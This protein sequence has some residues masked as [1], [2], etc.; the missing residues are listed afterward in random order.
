MLK[1]IYLKFNHCLFFA[2]FTSYL[3]LSS[4]SLLGQKNIDTE[5]KW[6]GTWATAPQLVEPHNMPPEPGLTNNSLRQIVRVS[7]GGDTL[8]IKFSNEFST[9]PVTMKSVQI[10]V[11]TGENTINLST[12]KELTFGG[13][14]EITMD[15]GSAVTSDP[16]A[17]RLEPRMD[18][19]ITIYYGQTSETTTGHPGSRTT[20]YLL[21]GNSTA[22]TDFTGAVPTDHWYNINTIDVLASSQA[23]CVAILGNSITDGRGSITNQQNRWPDMFSESL[24]KNPETQHIGVLNMGIGG[25][26]VLAGGLGPTG[27]KRYERDI[28]NQ[29]GIRWAIIYHGVN[30]IG[31]VK[32]AEAAETTAN[33]LIAAYKLMITD[34]HN[35]K[36]RIFGATILPFKGN[37]YYNEHSE[38]CRNTVNDWI[39]NSG[40]FDAVIDFDKVMRSPDDSTRLVSTYQNDGLHPDAASYKKMGESIDVNLFVDFDAD[41]P[42]KE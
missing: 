14:A 7:I 17:F 37:S 35:R 15:A 3:L 36:I 12:N 1:Y 41:F 25:N 24:L 10:A 18:V 13:N 38:L 6:V 29:S 40:Q 11:S 9:S 16:V 39:R 22:I 5:K 30:D 31:G 4:C 34:A 27:I 28:L 19:A 42:D 21:A 32:N 23:A 20:S 2:I 33:K 8:R 26:A